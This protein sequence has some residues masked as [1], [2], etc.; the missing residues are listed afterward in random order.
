MYR[1]FI[2]PQLNKFNNSLV[3]YE[4]LIRYRT[5]D[6]DR[7]TLPES[8]D[9]IP[10][11]VQV[12]LLKATASELALK[13][14]SVSIN[15]NRKQ[16]LNDAIAA[17][18]IAAQKQLFP[19]QVIVEVTEETDEDR[20]TLAE[21]QQQ[22]D[23]YKANGLQFS[24]DDVG[25]GINV[26]D[27][28]KPLLNSAEEIKFAMQN[29]RAED[30]EN[31]IPIQLKFWRDIAQEY[32]V[33]LILEGVENDAEDQMADDLNISLRQGYYYGKPHLFK[34]KADR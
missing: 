20:Y 7:W 25:T 32:D 27:H 13:I 24:I 1:Y 29:F 2:Q 4:M 34:L 5:S 31:E 16:F 12:D 8:F 10:I 28:I 6:T 21:M 30:R 18:V 33:R 22:I 9:N 3:G 17:A 19:V 14:G 26:Y 11:D 23:K 15:F